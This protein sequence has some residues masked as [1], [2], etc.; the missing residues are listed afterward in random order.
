MNEKQPNIWFEIIDL[1]KVV[2]PYLIIIFVAYISYKFGKKKS[3]FEKHLQVVEKQITEFYSPILGYIYRI[4]AAN[5]LEQELSEKANEAWEEIAKSNLNKNEQDEEFKLFQKLI[6][7]NNRIFNE[8]LLPLYNKM[9]KIFTDN[10]WLAEESTKDYYKD[11]SRYVDVWE[12]YQNKSIPRQ[13]LIKLKGD[14][15]LLISFK[16]DIKNNLEKLK[17]ILVIS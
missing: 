15:S 16:T 9:H 6:E 13:V 5:E 2:V 12:R 10:Y 4:E 1:A 11:L 14:E 17:N 8:E 3:R 7:N